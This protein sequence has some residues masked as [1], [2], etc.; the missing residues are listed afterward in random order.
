MEEMCS[1][2]HVTFFSTV[3]FS[4]ALACPGY[5]YYARNVSTVRIRVKVLRSTLRRTVKVDELNNYD[6]RV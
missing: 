4:G 3:S 6:R 2:T 5:R 1:I